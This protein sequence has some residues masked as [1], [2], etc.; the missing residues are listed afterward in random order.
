MKQ[1]YTLDA[2]DFQRKKMNFWFIWT[3]GNALGAAIGWTL[4]ETFGRITS[5]FWGD[6]VGML[7]ATLAFEIPVWIPRIWIARHFREL[8]LLGYLEMLIWMTTEVVGCF[9]APLAIS[10]KVTW[11]TLGATGADIT[12]TALSMVFSIIGFSESRFVALSRSKV[13]N[14]TQKV[15]GKRVIKTSIKAIF[16]LSGLVVLFYIILD[17]S[18]EISK[19]AQ[20]FPPMISWIL[21]GLFFGGCIGAITGLMYTKSI[22][23]RES[24]LEG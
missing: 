3:A 15:S 24:V 20:L 7:I 18:G 9:V 6:V 16:S 2:E 13:L 14:Q 11:F 19:N 4:G 23:Q 8:N 1:Y 5:H 21:S 17:A 10:G 12:G 22:S